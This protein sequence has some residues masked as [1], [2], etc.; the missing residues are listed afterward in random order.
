MYEPT[1]RNALVATAIVCLT[2]IGATAGV[3]AMVSQGRPL[4][5]TLAV[6]ALAVG[7][8]VG[9]LLR[10][11]MR[12]GGRGSNRWWLVFAVLVST[13]L[14]STPDAVQATVIGALSGFL[15]VCAVTMTRRYV[16]P[17]RPGNRSR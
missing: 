12:P 1:R 3:V 17:S 16:L 6:V 7:I 4:T 8:G 5:A 9:W 15:V 13:L 14:V 10:H 2:A 11:E